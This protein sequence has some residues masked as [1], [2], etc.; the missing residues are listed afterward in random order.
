MAPAI[1]V[2]ICEIKV[3]SDGAGIFE[4]IMRVVVRSPPEYLGFVAE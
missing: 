4:P 1:H 3:N 2:V